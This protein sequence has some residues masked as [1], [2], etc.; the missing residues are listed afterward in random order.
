M[1]QRRTALAVGTFGQ[2]LLALTSAAFGALFSGLVGGAAQDA[3]TWLLL[4]ALV[5]AASAG[6]L[7]ALRLS[8]ILSALRASRAHQTLTLL[9][10]DDI[11]S[12]AARELA[13][14]K[15][16]RVIG[17]AREDA[18]ASNRW[19]REYLRETERRVRG[20]PIVYRRITSRPRTALFSDHI[21]A[22]GEIACSHNRDV[23]IRTAE[24]LS[25]AVSYQVFDE[26]LAMIIV[27]VPHA[28]ERVENGIGVSTTNEALVRALI[29]HFDHAWRTLNEQR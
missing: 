14:S 27:D 10:T 22:L 16:V 12:F 11:S 18:L 21:E 24:D 2:V 23:A 6:L 26:R 17:T 9:H 4:V 29:S 8:Q 7:G 25:I 3:P 19:A 1:H 15:V 5:L 13:S 28:P 20:A